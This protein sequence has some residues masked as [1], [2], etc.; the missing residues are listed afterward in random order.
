MSNHDGIVIAQVKRFRDTPIPPHHVAV[1]AHLVDHIVIADAADHTTT[2]GH[3]NDSSLY[4]YSKSAPPSPQ[5][6]M[7]YLGK[8]C[9]VAHD[10]LRSG[11]VANLGIGLPEEIAVQAARPGLLDSSP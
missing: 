9:S 11:Q 7:I 1:P 8:S 3:T 10:E 5:Q 6:V 4:T 2:L